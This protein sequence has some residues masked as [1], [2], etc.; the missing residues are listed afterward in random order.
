M[1]GGE[2]IV[3]SL[4]AHGVDTVFGLPGVQLYGLF[5]A[6]A[7]EANR[8]RVINAR[9]EQGV[10]YMALGAAAS[11]GKPAVYSVVP[12]PGVLNTTA[13]LA[14]AAGINAPVLCV[15]G[16]VPSSFLGRGRGHLHELPD[17]LATLRTLVKRAERIEDAEAAPRL[18]AEAF[19]TM[20][21]GRR[22][23][24]TLEMPWDKLQEVGEV[25]PLEPLP[26]IT[27]PVPDPVRI[28]EAARLALAAKAPLIVVGGGAA[29]AGD[30]VRALA[31]RLGA[32]VVSYRSG[33]GVVDDH[34]PLSITVAAVHALWPQT[35]LVIGI[36]SRLEGPGWR[37]APQEAPAKLIRIDIDPVEMRRLP[38]DV[39]IVADAP[40][41][42]RALVEA[43]G[44]GAAAG[45]RTDIANAKRAAATLIT[46]ARPH[47]E[48][49]QTIRA[50]LPAD[51]FLVDEMCQAGYASWFAF[52]VHRPRTI[53]TSGF[54]GTL[55]SGFP[56]ALGVAA[57]NPGRKVISLTGDGGFLFGATELATAVQFR[58]GVTVIVFENGAYGNVKRDQQRLFE[59]RSAGSDLANPDFVRFAESFGVPG[60]R[61]E[62]DADFADTLAAAMEVNGPALVHVRTRLAEEVSPWRFIAPSRP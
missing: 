51:G 48:Y 11:T 55:G 15:T 27:P 58:L 60:F 26:T 52:P 25:T 6:L 32:P 22:G 20:M 12:G 24:V 13:A 18:V 35:D 47:Y 19:Q 39:G 1:T 5:D 44:P 33:R 53:I 21:A 38:A 10:A 16:Q 49:L 34:H 46:E 56:T 59:G 8:I 23:P 42:T 36:G 7:R 54:Q 43:L 17:Q 30:A 4:L 45:R 41:A 9:H 40:A 2:A 61:V 28:D 29:E 3:G 14:T 62:R 50:A 31:E 37:W 57:A